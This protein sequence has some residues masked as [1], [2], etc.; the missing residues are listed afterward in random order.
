[1]PIRND[2]SPIQIQPLSP[3]PSDIERET[4]LLRQ[5][6]ESTEVKSF[7]TNTPKSKKKGGRGNG[8]ANRGKKLN[9]TEE[10]REKRKRVG[11]ENAKKTNKIRAEKVAKLKVLEQ[12]AKEKDDLLER[13]CLRL[14]NYLSTGEPSRK[15]PIVEKKINPRDFIPRR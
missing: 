1:M 5:Q 7:D 15:K 10:Q 14:T 12:Q 13:V 6:E 4:E 9:L 3:T 11:R 8:G 2:D